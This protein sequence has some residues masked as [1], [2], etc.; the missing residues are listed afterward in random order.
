MCD[1]RHVRCL[2]EQYPHYELSSAEMIVA[3]PGTR[4]QLLQRVTERGATDPEFRAQ[5]LADPKAAIH[6]TFGVRVPHGFRIRFI[7]KGS[8]VDALVVLPDLPTTGEL[9][10][11]LLDAVAG[12][13]GDPTDSG[14]W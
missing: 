7:E 9:S 13:V 11:D 1:F 4:E 3:H 12:G 2:E 5:L 6:E 14:W 10:E 8:D